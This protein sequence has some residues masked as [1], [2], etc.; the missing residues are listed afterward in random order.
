MTV[1]AMD[2]GAK[3]TVYPVGGGTAWQDPAA[4]VVATSTFVLIVLAAELSTPVRRRRR[5]RTWLAD[6]IAAE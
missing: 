1:P 5:A 4:G 3:D 6:E 2:T